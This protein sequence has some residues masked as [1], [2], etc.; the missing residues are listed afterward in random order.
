MWL[1]TPR[2]QSRHSR[3]QQEA[4]QSLMDKD[5][6]RERRVL[7]FHSPPPTWGF[8]NILHSPLASHVQM[9]HLPGRPPTWD[10]LGCRSRVCHGPRASRPASTRF[11]VCTRPRPHRLLIGLETPGVAG[12]WAKSSPVAV[13]FSSSLKGPAFPVLDGAY[14]QGLFGEV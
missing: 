13:K 4:E 14:R 10:P 7:P 1:P 11:R 3:L 9:N 6:P 2:R 12:D 8:R 5:S